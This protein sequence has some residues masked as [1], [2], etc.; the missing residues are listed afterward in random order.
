[1]VSLLWFD[2]HRT[3]KHWGDCFDRDLL[4]QVLKLLFLYG[5]IRVIS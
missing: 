4:F 2:V 1:M 5:V 3:S